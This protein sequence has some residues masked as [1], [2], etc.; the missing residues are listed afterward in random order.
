[1]PENVRG[2]LADVLGQGVLAP[3]DERERATREDEVDRCPR[4][5]AER[6]EA[7]ELTEPDRRDVAGCGRELDGV[8]DEGGIDE[9]L[10]RRGLKR[11]ELV[12]LDRA[13]TTNSSVGVGYPTR[14][15]SMKRS[16]WASGKG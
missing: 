15:L 12:G 11:E 8:L 13:T 16:T 10:V 4:A 14:T 2:E 5:R 7:R 6:D 1:M 3:A 9:D